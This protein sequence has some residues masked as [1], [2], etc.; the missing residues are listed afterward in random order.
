MLASDQNGNPRQVR[1]RKGQVTNTTYD[2]LN[3]PKVVTWADSSTTTLTW[4]AGN[5]LTQLVDSIV[6]L[7][8]GFVS[9]PR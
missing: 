4:D 8:C 5:R 7:P 6:C 1:D 2:P 9:I 3:R